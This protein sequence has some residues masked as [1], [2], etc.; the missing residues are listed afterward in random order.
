MTNAEL[1]AR[2]ERAQTGVLQ[3]AEEMQA[4]RDGRLYPNA[5]KKQGDSWGA[6][7]KERWGLTSGAVDQTIVALPVLQRLNTAAP[8]GGIGV[9]A[10]AAVASLPEGVQ[11][12]ILEGRPKR[13][14]VKAR[15][16]AARQAAKKAEHRGRQV[17]DEEQIAA[18]KQ[19]KVAKPKPKPEPVSVPEDLKDENLPP[20]LTP[21]DHGSPTRKLTGDAL[22]T[23]W[24]ANEKL[25]DEALADEDRQVIDGKLE[26]ITELARHM[27]AVLRGEGVISDDD[28]AGL[29]E[30]AHG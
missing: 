28:L 12:A 11:D 26:K 14:V 16:K 8:G 23:L 29:L 18:A 20:K 21:E 3:F 5:G 24:R 27:Q 9:S 10:A 1:A 22:F 13:D 6:Y 30:N 19:A 15:A 4:I 25:K 2:E 7:C 17:T